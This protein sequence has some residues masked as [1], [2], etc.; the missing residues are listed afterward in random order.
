MRCPTLDQLP[1]PPTDKTG[2]PW[3]RESPQLPDRAPDG[4]EWP[5][6]SIVTP[7]YN[8]GEFLEETI[9]S[10][11]LQGYPNLEYIIIDGGSTDNSV[12]IIK[13]YEKWIKYWKS[14]KDKGQSHAINKGFQY[15]IGDV[16]AWLNS[17]D[18]YFKGALETVGQQFASVIQPTV[19]VGSGDI[20][21][22]E[23]KYLCEKTVPLLT[24]ENIVGGKEWF[25]QQSCFWSKSCWCENGGVDEELNL[26]MDLDLWIRF[27][28]HYTMI[29]CETKLGKLRWY[30][31]AK[32]V[33]YKGRSHAERILLDIR[34]GEEKTGLKRIEELTKNLSETNKEL[35]NIKGKITFKI[36][37]R[38]GFL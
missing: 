5:K 6:I 8:Q 32:S 21:D 19:L 4:E 10:V 30:E 9:R 3:T 23:G 26:L 12:E 37:R 16:F 22:S 24:M 29:P 33:K 36:M 13:K 14:E 18:T 11:L 1:S 31:N 27:S 35:S 17:D 25:L 15:A 38:L 2:W 20:V 7:S 34:Y 28:K